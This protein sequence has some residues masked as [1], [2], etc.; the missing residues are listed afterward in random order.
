MQAKGGMVAAR[1]AS[2]PWEL[3]TPGCPREDELGAWRLAGGGRH[4]GRPVLKGAERDTR[5]GAARTDGA[6]DRRDKVG[7]AC[8][9][10]AAR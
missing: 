4:A 3:V 7:D 10:R 8:I 2:A 5:Q 1:A 9:D 6:H